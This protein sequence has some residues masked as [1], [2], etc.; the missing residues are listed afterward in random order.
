MLAWY[1]YGTGFQPIGAAGCW[2]LL[3]CASLSAALYPPVVQI[4]QQQHAVAIA[5]TAQFGVRWLASVLQLIM[6]IRDGVEQRRV[7]QYT[8]MQSEVSDVKSDPEDLVEDTS[9]LRVT[10]FS[11]LFFAWVSPLMHTGNERALEDSDIPS[12]QSEFR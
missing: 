12:I 1:L 9:G 10:H 7:Q 11:K 8:R 5:Y 2:N 6:S 4:F 3:S